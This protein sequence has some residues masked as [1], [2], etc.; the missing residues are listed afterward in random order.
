MLRT[1]V[2]LKAGLVEVATAVCV[3]SASGF[4]SLRAQESL[5]AASQSYGEC[6]CKVHRP[7]SLYKV[8]ALGV[9]FF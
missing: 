4:L 9:V 3:F 5:R 7:R 2:I 8:R 6:V 1:T